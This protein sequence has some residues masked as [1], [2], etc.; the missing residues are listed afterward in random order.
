MNTE[1]L[2]NLIFVIG[3]LLA[4]LIFG[5]N[6]LKSLKLRLILLI[7]VLIPAIIF[8]YGFFVPESIFGKEAIQGFILKFGVFS[9]LGLILIQILQVLIPPLDHNA[10]QFIGGLLFGPYLGFIYNFIGRTLGSVLAF[11]IGKKYG[12]AFLERVAPSEDI[13]KYDNI[14]NKNSLFVFL[15]YWL[16]FFPDDTI[17]YLAGISKTRLKKFFLVLLIG[18]PVGVLGTT[19]M[20]TLGET[21]WFKNPVFWIVGFT[22]L[23]IGVVIFGFERFRKRTSTEGN[24]V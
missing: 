5:F 21:A 10:T 2:L 12:R 18:Q 7:A 17:S 20:G 22:T 23:F 24:S 16:P 9:V 3:T 11:S 1:A 6:K 4:T 14:W 15:A 13:K 19:L 8:V